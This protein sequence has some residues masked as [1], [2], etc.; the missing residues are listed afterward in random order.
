MTTKQVSFLLVILGITGLVFSYSMYQKNVTIPREKLIRETTQ[1]TLDRQAAERVETQ[2]QEK[3]DERNRRLDL[4]TNEAN[5]MYTRYLELNME[6]KEDGTYSG[7][8]WKWDAAAKQ[9]K[10]AKELCF[11]QYK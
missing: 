10:D 9:R 4:C 2:K 1:A 6:E 5:R 8:T 11:K 3:I 7:E